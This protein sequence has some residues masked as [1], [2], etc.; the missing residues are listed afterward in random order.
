MDVR[1]VLKLVI[2]LMETSG[3]DY[4]KEWERADEAIAHAKVYYPEAYQ[5][6]IDN[7]Q[8]CVDYY[9]QSPQKEV[10]NG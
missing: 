4:T 7:I 1:E 6:A 10:K 3:P 5:L 2:I 8:Q 9:S